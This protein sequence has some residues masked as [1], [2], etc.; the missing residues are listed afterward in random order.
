MTYTRERSQLIEWPKGYTEAIRDRYRKAAEELW[1][2]PIVPQADR[3]RE[4]VDGIFARALRRAIDECEQARTCWPDEHRQQHLREA[5]SDWVG[6]RE[7]CDALISFT[8]SKNP[9]VRDKLSRAF[10][11]T[12]PSSGEDLE[13]FLT[14]L[15]SFLE[16]VRQGSAQLAF[17]SGWRFGPLCLPSLSHDWRQPL[18]AKSTI[19]ALALVHCFACLK[20]RR[21]ETGAVS[22]GQCWE[23]A[24]DFAMRAIGDI[25]CKR[26]SIQSAAEQLFDRHGGKNDWNIYYKGWEA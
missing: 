17:A 2:S 16:I 7:G 3:D 6:A 14:R 12:R 18:P 5:K 4:N 9:F 23:A 22:E 19:L 11:H 10:L 20:S 25:N 1:N 26:K 15:R 8:E 13:T 21:D 24:A